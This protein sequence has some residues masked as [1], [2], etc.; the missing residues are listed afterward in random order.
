MQNTT[1]IG[2]IALAVALSATLVS[3][4]F[5]ADATVGLDLNSAYVWRGITFNDGAVL[6][7]SVD[8][9]HSSGAGLNVWGNLDIDDYDNTLESGEF[10]EV[11][12]TLYYALPVEEVDMSVGY[13]EYLFPATSTNGGALGTREIYFSAGQ[14]LGQYS[15]EL[16]GLSWGF[17]FAYDFDEVDDYY[18]NVSLAYGYDVNEQVSLELGGLVGYAGSDASAGADGGFNEW[19]IALSGSYAVAE[20]VDLGAFIAYVDT[21]DE[22][23]LP[24]QDTDVYGGVSVYYGF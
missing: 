3:P 6:Q 5:A 19:Q 1:R 11:D 10:S 21:L 8:V 24:S 2:L 4:A 9:A 16:A 18:S 22:D 12:L 15:E 13:I 17:F 23:V 7:P 20:G 14:D